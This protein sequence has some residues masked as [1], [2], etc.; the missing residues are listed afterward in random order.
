MALRGFASAIALAATF[1][2]TAPASAQDVDLGLSTAW[3]GAAPAS[4]SLPWV[5]VLLRDFSAAGDLGTYEWIRPT[6]EMQ[7]T[8]GQG[9]F[10]SPNPGGCCDVT[11]KGNLVPGETLQALY[12]NLNPRLD[13]RKLKLYWTGA[14]MPPGPAG[15]NV[16]PAAGLRPVSIEIAPNAFALDGAG[17]FD[18]KIV[19]NGQDKLG[20]EFQHSQ[21]LFVYDDPSVDLS[22]EDFF[23]ISTGANSS[24]APFVAVGVVKGIDGSKTGWIKN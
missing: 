2:L 19:W 22:P 14:P 10:S 21:L 9:I 5:N 20:G 7:V 13:A 15:S 8:T 6:V 1:H 24:S 23:A 11:G 3:K 4:T 17:R 12:M 18:I 16:F